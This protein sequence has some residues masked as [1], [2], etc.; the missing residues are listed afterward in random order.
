MITCAVCGQVM[1][2]DDGWLIRQKAAGGG[3][4]ALCPKHYRRSPLAEYMASDDLIDDQY[5]SVER[6]HKRK[7]RIGDK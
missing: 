7:V 1:D 6:E 5:Y 4:F 2:N 3:Y